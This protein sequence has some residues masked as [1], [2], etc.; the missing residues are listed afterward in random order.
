MRARAR[1]FQ[2]DKP[3]TQSGQAGTQAWVLEWEPSAPRLPDPVMGWAGSGDTQTQVRL[4]F[5]SREA[6]VAYAERNGVQYELELPAARVHKPK[7]YADNFRYD[8]KEM[9][10]H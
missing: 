9:W 2:Q 7:V 4:R 8:R 3:A 1:I 5:D 10:T 6:A